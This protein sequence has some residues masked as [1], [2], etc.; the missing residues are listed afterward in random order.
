VTATTLESETPATRLE[1]SPTF[2]AL[3]SELR[4]FLSS[5]VSQA[6]VV[7]G[8]PGS[9]KTMLALKLLE[10]FPG[11]K[12]LL[13]GRA[14]RDRL[15][16][17]H[18]WLV[19]RPAGLQ[20]LT[21][22][23]AV[24]SSKDARASL[25]SLKRFFQVQSE[26]ETGKAAA[27]A[28]AGGAAAGE[29]P[30]IL[31]VADPWESL[32][33]KYLPGPV[34]GQPETRRSEVEH[35]VLQLLSQLGTHVVAVLETEVP[36]T[37]DYLG[38]G[39]V[40]LSAESIDGR[41]ERW[42]TLAKLRG[43]AIE[44]ARCPFTL[45][46]GEFRAFPP[47]PL[48]LQWSLPPIEPAPDPDGDALWPGLRSFAQH[49]GRLPA[50]RLTLIESEPDVPHEWVTFLVAPMEYSALLQGANLALLPHPSQGVPSPLGRV[51]LVADR[52]RFLGQT[53]I[54]VPESFRPVPPEIESAVMRLPPTA[55]ATGEE[56]S[57]PPD[58]F[59]NV[60]RNAD[61]PNLLVFDTEGARALAPLQVAAL[62]RERILRDT[63]RNL[64][65]GA[66]H[67]IVEGQV[68]DPLV[69]ALADF[70]SLR[71]RLYNRHGRLIV[72]RAHPPS[73]AFAVETGA[74]GFYDI[75]PIV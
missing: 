61:V 33:D 7:G 69:G 6:L 63:Q 29:R 36:S 62:T 40:R 15:V 13:T 50:G 3:P 23:E 20:I 1:G 31:V 35:L 42:L 2:G 53:R 32:I 28:R 22:A 48:Q 56:P 16:K 34:D 26:A 25:G 70:A 65:R 52:A 9:G 73:P 27:P 24:G 72:H 30:A 17:D 68:G 37:L 10:W 54:I 38:T 43:T 8:P 64:A 14:N 55:V 66:F 67:A 58:P 71:L 47:M 74:H 21:T 75:S 18:P 5:G 4:T 57:A 41:R 46:D 39:V 49:F 51:L 60:R 44:D 19:T 12:I 59:L 45:A 11:Q